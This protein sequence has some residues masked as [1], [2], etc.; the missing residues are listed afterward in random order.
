MKCLFVR[1]KH[2]SNAIGFI[3]TGLPAEAA[4]E[5]EKPDIKKTLDAVLQ[6]RFVLFKSVRVTR[7]VALGQTYLRQKMPRLAFYPGQRCRQHF[8]LG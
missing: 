2:F 3:L 1:K 4:D 7:Y 5:L 6:V 8:Y